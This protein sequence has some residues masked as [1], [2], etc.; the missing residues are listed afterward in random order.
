MYRVIALFAA[1]VM[2]IALALGSGPV[3]AWAEGEAGQTV[4]S[5]DAGISEGSG[6][7][8]GIR[9]VNEA[10]IQAKVKEIES[11]FYGALNPIVGLMSK[12]SFGIAAL[13]LILALVI[14]TGVLKRVL[15]VLF[16][17]ALGI[18]LWANAG[19]LAEWIMSLSKWLGQ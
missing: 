7:S 12:V 3:P 8:G 5:T 13:A 6:S 11:T 4:V 18:F 17:V 2:V 14:G 9:P 16:C 1:L 19:K 15:S 10:K